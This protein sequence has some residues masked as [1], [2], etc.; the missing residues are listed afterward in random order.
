MALFSNRLQS[1]SK[2]ELF[3]RIIMP[4]EISS[5]LSSLNTYT[6]FASLIWGSLG[7]GI[8]IYG[9]KQKVMIP[10]WAGML[11]V[12][13]S[14]FISSALLMSLA[15]ILILVGMYWLKKQGY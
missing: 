9:W 5:F 4:P 1:G 3:W 12:G 14:F 11:M 7:S 2:P 8:F 15:S 13:G 10:V 6:L